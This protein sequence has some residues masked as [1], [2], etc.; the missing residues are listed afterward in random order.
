MSPAPRPIVLVGLPGAGKSTVGR[1]AARLLETGFVDLDGLIASRTGST[2]ERYIEENGESAFRACEAEM[3]RE[4]L[5]GPPA[6]VATGGGYFA[7]PENRRQAIERGFPVYLHVSPSVAARRLGSAA[8]R[9]LLKGYDLTLRLAQLLQQRQAAY[10][11]ATAKV[12][13]DQLTAE[14]AAERV[15]VLARSDGGW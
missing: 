4:V 5:A 15:A 9:P 12:S 1:Q 3:A 2:V 10:L 6:V 13:T 8:G 14:Q 7:D 11:E